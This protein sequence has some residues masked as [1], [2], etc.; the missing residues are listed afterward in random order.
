MAKARPQSPPGGG[1]SP[2]SPP[3]L[4]SP[5]DCG[6]VNIPAASSSAYRASGAGLHAAIATRPAQFTVHALSPRGDFV[7]NKRTWRRGDPS[8]HEPPFSVAIRGPGSVKIGA[9][10]QS[11]EDGAHTITWVAKVSGEYTISVCER[12]GAHIIGSPF[13]AAVTVAH[14]DPMACLLSG[15]G[16]NHAIAGE[17][18]RFRV[19]YRDAA[20]RDVPAEPLDLTLHSADFSNDG[21]SHFDAADVASHAGFANGGLV[22]PS[23]AGN[24]TSNPKSN[25]A[26]GCVCEQQ[27]AINRAGEYLLHV[28][29]RS[30]AMP[31]RGSPFAL[32][33]HGGP[34]H[35]RTTSCLS[36]L[37]KGRK[38]VESSAGEPG[39]LRFRAVDR[40]G[41]LCHDGGANVTAY[42][43]DVEQ[44]DDAVARRISSDATDGDD[45]G[46]MG[47]RHIVA[48]DVGDGTA[49]S[50][51]T[52][53]RA[54]TECAR[55]RW[56]T[57]P[58]T[59][60]GTSRRQVPSSQHCPLWC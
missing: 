3:L 36:E 41:N 39:K 27:Y 25:D 5:P 32:T 2:S 6:G 38:M 16:L 8:G 31:V 51:D 53:G 45:F 46:R 33:V 50:M 10:E 17:S 54:P 49:T 55:I 34:A 43:I 22:T 29:L 47:I 40:L 56:A 60:G 13:T 52:F 11:S 44:V 15:A 59:Q 57:H 7:A 14:A 42:A 58:H 4:P 12:H 1:A 24:P 21:D 18:T 28:R 26:A 35:A 37:P 30:S 20:D 9:A 48:K 19:E 23:S